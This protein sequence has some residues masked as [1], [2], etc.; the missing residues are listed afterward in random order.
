ME[1]NTLTV[2]PGKTQ[3]Y[4]NLVHLK[5]T[6]ARLCVSQAARQSGSC[7]SDTTHCL[8]AESYFTTYFAPCGSL[9]FACNIPHSR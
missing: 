2:S 7:L 5:I 1:K 3:G 8:T 9:S 4:D 6:L